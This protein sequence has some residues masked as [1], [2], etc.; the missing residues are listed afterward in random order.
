MGEGRKE[1]LRVG[2]DLSVKIEFRGA[3]SLARI[4]YEKGGEIR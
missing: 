4:F 1:A 3:M 2:M